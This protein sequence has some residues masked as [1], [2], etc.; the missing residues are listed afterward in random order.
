MNNYNWMPW[1]IGGVLVLS[2]LYRKV[3][4][5]VRVIIRSFQGIRLKSNSKLSE[6]QYKKL[7]IGSLYAYQQGGY[8]NTLTLDIKDRLPTLLGKWWGISSARDAEETLEYLCGKGY[9]YYFPYVYKAFLL[10]DEQEQDDVFQQNMTNQEDYDKAVEQLKNL[11]ETYEE[12][13]ETGTIASKEDLA[14]YGA[15]GWDAGRLNFMA[16]ACYDAN[17]ISEAQAWEYIDKAYEMAHSRFT[18]WHDMAMS[19]V[20]GRALW[21]GTGHFNSG[22]KHSADDLLS[23]PN[24]PWVQMKW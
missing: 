11:K 6:E 8:L 24:S 7:S 19:Y 22:M 18:S 13:I 17:Y 21:G 12:L 10:N 14:R 9:D 15:L 20:I 5:T 2:F 4:P 23:Q 16:R 3:W 1:A